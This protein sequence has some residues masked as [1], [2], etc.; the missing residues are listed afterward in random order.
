L[1]VI[2]E[3]DSSPRNA[4]TLCQ[5]NE[6]ILGF[7][8]EL[9]KILADYQRKASCDLKRKNRPERL[10]IQWRWKNPAAKLRDKN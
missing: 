10:L 7:G 2:F 5:E 8:K 4:K 9:S 1:V 3:R 6:R